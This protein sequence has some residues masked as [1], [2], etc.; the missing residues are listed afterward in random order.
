MELAQRGESNMTFASDIVSSLLRT[1]RSL[2]RRRAYTS[3]VVAILCLGIGSSTAI[4]SL[5]DA[6]L[7]KSL[8]FDRPDSIAVLFA[9]GSARGQGNRMAT[10]VGDFVDWRANASP[11]FTALAALRNESRRITSVDTPVV[12]LVHAVSANYFDVL[13]S[14]PLVGRTFREGE[15]TPGR[16]GVV[17]VSYAIWQ[18]VFGGD[19]SV[20]G[21]VIDL[22]GKPHTV[23]GIMPAD[24]YTA[25]IFNVQP[26]L[27]VPAPFDAQRADRLTRDVLVY[28]RMADGVSLERAQAAMAAAAT[29]ISQAHPDTDDRWSIALVPVREH[30]V[31]AFTH[32][33][34]ALLVA[35]GLVLLIACAN[36]AN[37]ALVRGAERAGEIAVRTAL[38]ASRGQITAELLL[39]S[40]VLA[41]AG[42]AVGTVLATLVLPLLVHLIP[43]GSGVP[44]LDRAV[45]DARVLAFATAASIGSAMLVALLPSRQASRIDVVAGLRSSARGSVQSAGGPWRQAI[46]G[47]EVAL[48]VVVVMSAALMWQTL[49]RLDR[50]P[51]GFAV[52]R[53]AKLRTS[54]R[55]DAFATPSARIAHFDE[56]QRQLQNVAGVE[57]VSGVSFEPPTQ[58][59]MI[60]AVRLRLPG[61]SDDA[62][63]AP[64]AVSRAVLPDYFEAMSIPIV[65]GRPLSHADR[66]DGARVAVISVTMARR[67]FADVDPIGRAFAVDAPGAPPLT[68]VGVAG[69]VLSAGLDPAPQPIFYVPYAQNAAPV[70]TMVMRVPQGD[71]KA[72][73]R[74]AERIAWGI[75]PATN[76]YAVGTIARDMADA[77]WRTRFAASVMGGFAG[78]SLLLAAAGLYVVVSYT[79]LQRRAEIG[80]RIALGASA[81]DIVSMVLRDGLRAVVVGL[82]IGAAAAAALTQ[83]MAGLLYGVRPGD[84]PTLIAVSLGLL[85]VAVVACAEPAIRAS[86]L[87]P[88]LAL[89]D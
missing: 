11:A 3:M 45:V 74:E 32:V 50:T 17:V 37:L 39:E 89:R 83:T 22:D 65:S 18:T 16:E 36:V 23:I 4:F 12:P 6:V 31:G 49:L 27:W 70:M 57:S 62:A 82:V 84:V 42:G 20:V 68:I 34:G 60:S 7:L 43:I 61:R 52:D 30:T 25:H 80:M 48:A 85:V 38:G 26:G 29:R 15:D 56:L 47:G 81:A 40:S 53:I 78:L 8:P 58:A 71:P 87:D 19:R 54:L 86:R 28:G 51:A 35:V 73:L 69:D 5:V 9:D 46:V 63:S 10:T 21:R 72:V 55:G 2:N 13:G 66:R 14:R 24:F 79:V 76:V 77:N 67:C 75:S 1:I 88:Q 44:F 59:G 41:L 64:A 33:A